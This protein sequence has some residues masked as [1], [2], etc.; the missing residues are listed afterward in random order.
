MARDIHP[1]TAPILPERVP[2]G[3]H[4]Q[5]AMRLIPA[6]P[7]EREITARRFLAGVKTAGCDLQNLWGVVDRTTPTPS[8]REVCMAI[9]GPGRTAMLFVSAPA[10]DETDDARALLDRAACIDAA[11]GHLDPHTVSIS[12][13]L[14]EPFEHW[15]IRAYQQ[16]GFT[17]VGELAYLELRLAPTPNKQAASPVRWPEGV[18]VRPVQDDLQPGSPDHGRLKRVLEASYADTLDCPELCGLRDTDDVIES[19]LATGSFDPKRWLLAFKDQQPVGCI[20][21]SLV[22]E[23]T[24]AELVYVGLAPTGRGF[25]LAQ[26]FLRR[27]IQDLAGTGANKLVCAVDRRNAPA[28]AIYAAFGFHEFSARDAWV[29]PNTHIRPRDVHRDCGKRG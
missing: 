13:G 25:G 29:K 11:T 1:N 7:H 27:S 23:T 10:P 4:L 12:Q 2:A 17:H 5:A 9:T 3:L 28:K 8:V 6:A 16:A 18:L 14:P 26:S 19:H 20:L 22:P 15:A 24:S 21:I